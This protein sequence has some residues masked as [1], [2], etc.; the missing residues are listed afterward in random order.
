MQTKK[1][2]LSISLTLSNPSFFEDFYILFHFKQNI[3]ASL[4]RAQRV[5]LRLMSKKGDKEAAKA[6]QLLDWSRED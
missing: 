1:I 6:S 3:K 2:T 4:R 5:R